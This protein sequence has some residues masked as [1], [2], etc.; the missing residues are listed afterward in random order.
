MKSEC[1]IRQF[2]KI[3]VLIS[4]LCN[5]RIQMFSA[6]RIYTPNYYSLCN[7]KLVVCLCNRSLCV[8]THLGCDGTRLKQNAQARL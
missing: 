3:L 8:E 6:H 1:T 2:L 5:G 7:F 4:T